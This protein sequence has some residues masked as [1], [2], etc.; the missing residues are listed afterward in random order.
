MNLDLL[1]RHMSRNRSTILLGNHTYHRTIF[2]KISD[3]DAALM[4]LMSYQ[5]ILKYKKKRNRN[6]KFNI[7]H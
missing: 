5:G 4:K 1:E 7:S 2:V 3:I 6:E